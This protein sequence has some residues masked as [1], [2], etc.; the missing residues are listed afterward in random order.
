[1]LFMLTSLD[2]EQTNIFL[3]CLNSHRRG[4]ANCPI[5]GENNW[6]PGDIIAPPRYSGRNVRIG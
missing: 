3:D 5:C 2:Q 1:M 6:T 4:D